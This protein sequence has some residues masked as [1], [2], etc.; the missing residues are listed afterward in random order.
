MG[1]VQFGLL[2]ALSAAAIP[3]IIHLVF[4]RRARRVDL[5]TLRFLKIVLSEN[6]RRRR[7]KRWLLL[8]LRMAAAALLACLFARPY[9]LSP[10][11]TDDDRLVVI[12][13]DRSASMGLRTQ[14]GRLLDLAVAE[15]RK[16]VA[17]C[18]EGTQLRIAWF[19]N[20]VHPLGGD[21][22][23][24]GEPSQPLG[25]HPDLSPPQTVYLPTDYGAALAWAGDLCVA[26]PRQSK[27]IYLLTDLQR[28]GLDRTPARPLPAD[29][30][31][32]LVTV[33]EPYPKNVAVTHATV[34]EPS[35][36]PGEPVTLTASLLSA[37]QL[38]TAKV[39]V[40]LHLR[41]GD[42]QQN[43]RREIDLD[44]G[45][46]GVVQFELSDLAE[47]LW[48]GYVMAEVEDDLP[49]D[50]RRHVAF[51]VA[52]QL[53]VLLVDGDPGHW[54]PAAETYFLEAALRLAPA[55]ESF[56]ESPFLPTTVA[57]GEGPW[58]PEAA[59]LLEDG[60]KLIV[61]ANVENCRTA[62][63][64]RLA[65][66]VDAGG[67]L[68]V[69]TGELVRAEGYQALDEVGLGVGKIVEVRTADA[70]PWRLDRWDAD[71][72]VFQP[73]SDPQ[74]GDPRRIAFRSYT[75]IEPHQG[76]LVPAR[77]RGGQPALLER[78]CGR[79]RVLWFT[80]ACDRQWGDW[81]RSRLFLPLVHQML[82]YLAGRANGGPVRY[83]LIDQTEAAHRD[84]VPGV[85]ARDR[86][87]Q[88]VNVD[89]RE[90]ETDRCTR[91]ELASR[92]AFRLQSNDGPQTAD[93][94][95][96]VAAPGPGSGVTHATLSVLP[97]MTGRPFA[98][99]DPLNEGP[100]HWGQF[101]AETAAAAKRNGSEATPA[102]FDR[103][104]IVMFAP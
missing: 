57:A 27:E 91:Q 8:A 102:A 98:G 32:H 42:R 82:S 77:F 51:L 62:D 72:P 24:S 53:R 52:P 74:S 83:V 10:Q 61:L 104:R 28:S 75:R 87:H 65:D 47:G 12:L 68:L 41:N 66:F 78:R 36:R 33:S 20:A 93:Q 19:D 58:M 100:R 22:L 38:A 89:P 97:Q 26:S 4:G 60:V 25:P 21:D 9:L 39:P 48:E 16:I 88:V 67:G 40:I 63:A 13:I 84:V 11:R 35:V 17:R 96:G 7:L 92:F 1:W 95:A 23:G 101:S 90:S 103:L 71:H 76:I 30:D 44:A 69:F 70:L 49:F 34:P 79:G 94:T 50:D 15:A 3:I 5:G 55:D 81:P 37:G 64:R 85:F 59:V 31:V 29:V 14:R 45:A 56:A 54:P 18:G 46:S 86:F 6:V 73:L 99:L 43:R 80:S 2:G